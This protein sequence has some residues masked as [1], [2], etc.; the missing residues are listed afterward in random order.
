M[1]ASVI[2]EKHSSAFQ[3]NMMWCMSVS[4][5]YCTGNWKQFRFSAI[6]T[7]WSTNSY[8]QRVRA[9]A[10]IMR[11]F[12]E[13]EW[14]TATRWPTE[15]IPIHR[16]REWWLLG[17]E[18]NIETEIHSISGRWKVN[19][20]GTQKPHRCDRSCSCSLRTRIVCDSQRIIGDDFRIPTIRRYDL[21]HTE[22][23]RF[24]MHSDSHYLTFT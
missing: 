19:A 7:V 20:G 9:Y 21:C 24:K 8:R 5:S 14:A 22:W 6:R 15:S 13:Q 16:E 11:Q 10:S 18:V 17:Y 1:A 2:L 3:P 23:L 4:I 12:D